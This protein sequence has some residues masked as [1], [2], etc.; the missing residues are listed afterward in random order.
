MTTNNQSPLTLDHD[1][2]YTI[3]N[4]NITIQLTS[5]PEPIEKIIQKYSQQN[6]HKFC[7]SER[8]QLLFLETSI[9]ITNL[10][11]PK[12]NIKHESLTVEHNG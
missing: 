3:V 8:T 1:Y 12:Y 4:M 10:T 9:W 6:M 5:E 11:A 2:S 7:T